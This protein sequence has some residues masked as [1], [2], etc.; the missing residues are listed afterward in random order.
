[1]TE[2]PPE[3]VIR[4]GWVY[5]DGFPVRN[6]ESLVSGG[7]RVEVREP[8]VLQGELKLAA[9]LAAFRPPVV[10][11][12]A[13]DVG[14]STGGFT[15]ALLAA[16]AARVYAADAGHGQLLGSL[17]QDG[18]VV[19][20]ERTNLAALGPELIPETIDLVT[21]DVSYLALARA[22]PQ[23]AR[24]PLAAGAELL[25]LVKPMYELGLGA[26]PPPEEIPE[27][28]ERARR[29]ILGAGWRVLG[30][31][32]SPVRGHGGA[33]EVWLHAVRPTDLSPW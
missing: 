21:I 13:L 20:L 11:K 16:G 7:A 2:R 26:L 32:E 28:V 19:V 10:G 27:A 3:D 30:T 14:A 1:V 4:A 15:R 29:G 23:L 31:I 18:R 25:A 33:R 6:P 22:V 12:V 24:V 5:V 9:A 17:R 8:R